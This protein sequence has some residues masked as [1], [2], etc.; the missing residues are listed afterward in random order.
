MIRGE[1][2]WVDYG[3]PYGSEPGYR[4][5]RSREWGR[6]VSGRREGGCESALRAGWQVK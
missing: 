1:V 4:R 3:I 2:W 5:L 6:G